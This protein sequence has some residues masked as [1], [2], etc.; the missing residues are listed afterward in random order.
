MFSNLI[1]YFVPTE[2]HKTE[3]SSRKAR[4]AVGVYLVISLFS[5]TYSVISLVINYWGG[6]IS[7]IPLLIVSVLCLFLYR[8]K[9]NPL[10]VAFLFFTEAIISISI[11]IYYSGGFNSFILPWLAT[12]PIVALL[13]SGKRMGLYTLFGQLTMLTMFY[14]FEEFNINP[15]EQYLANFPTLFILSCH[16]G[17]ILLLYAIANFFE[18]GKSDAMGLMSKK[19]DE[20]QH[21]IE[22]IKN[23]QGQLVQQEKLAS[24]GHLTAGISHELKNPLNF[25]NN[26]SELSIELVDEARDE[27]KRQKAKGNNKKEESP[28]A[29]GSER[30][31]Q[32]DIRNSETDTDPSSSDTPLNSLST[33]DLLLDILNDIE[34]N[35]KTIHK[36]GSRADSIIKSMLQHS[37]GSGVIMEPT[38]LNPLLKEFVNL[39]FHGMRASD[40]P[41][42]V[43][44]EFDLDPSIGEVP[45]IAEDFSRVMVNLCNNAFD[46]MREK[47]RTG[48]IETYIPRLFIR[49][50]KKDKVIN[51]VVEDNGTG[52]PES[53]R[54]KI[55]QPFFTTKKG[56]EGTGL[57][58]YITNDIIKAHG[59][60]LYIQ[61]EENK[62]TRFIIELN[63]KNG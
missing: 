4:L 12:T 41:I 63:D 6:I 27:V 1:K 15:A 23:M 59:G 34:S 42:E 48:D 7:Q 9:V 22:K 58:L 45:I 50:I 47:V 29:G 62:F 53:L 40:Q 37:R 5:F 16:A 31:E 38:K 39:S 44:I 52:I 49:T 19:N 2:Y 46:A 61:S 35:L 43:D 54:K 33:G 25:V 14:F 13:V 21:T 36:H 28:L 10:L 20:L 32:G 30:S 60:M 8:S 51:I 57:G 18:T 3:E 56:T 17:L 11:T 24:L 55:L 26:F